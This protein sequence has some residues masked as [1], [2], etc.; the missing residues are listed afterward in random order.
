MGREMR[1][2]PGRCAGESGQAAV[3]SALT[4][5]LVAFLF[6]GSLQL[7]LLLQGRLMAE[8][9]VYKAV[10]VGSVNQGSCTAMTHAAIGA[11]LP[12]IT[13]TDSPGALASA[14]QQHRRNQYQGTNI[15]IVEIIRLSPTGTPP[16]EEVND[17]PDTDVRLTIRL[18]F[19]FRMK[20]PFANWVM[21]KMFLAHYGLQSFTTA[22]P[23]FVVQKNANWSQKLDSFSSYSW[24][25]GAVD[26]RMLGWAGQKQYVFPIMLSATMRMM[27]PPRA[28]FFPPN[29]PQDCPINPNQTEI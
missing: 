26:T 3:E 8:Y 6:L 23:Y 14:F 13:R 1:G 10:R 9:A 4:L 2:Q 21:S 12:T 17:Y 18:L 20:V 28:A 5:P 15:P 24:P 27:T 7:F 22:N 11:V 29:H 19:W 25:G 16:A